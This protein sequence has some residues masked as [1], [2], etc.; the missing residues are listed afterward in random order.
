MSRISTPVAET[1]V[2]CSFSSKRRSTILFTALAKMELSFRV[3][4][5]ARKVALVPDGTGKMRITKPG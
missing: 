4:R 5:S 1:S 2:V 3:I